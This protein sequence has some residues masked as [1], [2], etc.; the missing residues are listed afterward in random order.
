MQIEVSREGQET[1][2]LKMG[3]NT[4]QAAL[5]SAPAPSKA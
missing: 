3:S 5:P 2:F 1:G 4:R